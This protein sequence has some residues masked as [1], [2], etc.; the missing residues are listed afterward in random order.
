MMLQIKFGCNRPAGLGD[1]HVWK[2]GWTH[3]RTDART[4]ARV[5]SYKLTLWAFGS[6]ELKTEKK[7]SKVYIQTTWTSSFQAGNICSFKTFHGKLWEELRPQGSQYIF[8]WKVTEW[9]NHRMTEG[10]GKSRTAPHFQ[11]NAINT[12]WIMIKLLLNINTCTVY[13]F[14]FCFASFDNLLA[15]FPKFKHPGL[16]V[17]KGSKIPVYRYVKWSLTFQDIENIMLT[18]INLSLVMRKPVF[19]V[20]D[21]ATLK[22]AYA[23][24]EAS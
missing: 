12:D 11:S 17:Q 14:Q 20:F 10:Q 21:Q 5:P 15:I 3:G 2:C 7:L 16:K 8:I 18:T 13:F 23:V 4:P 9:Q 24:T 6:G 22:P 1:I 19:G